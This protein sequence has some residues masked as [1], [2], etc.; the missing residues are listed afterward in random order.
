MHSFTLSLV[1]AFDV[2]LSSIPIVNTTKMMTATPSSIATQLSSIERRPYFL[3][4]SISPV[5][6]TVLD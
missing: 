4:P 3:A 2:C 6:R 5:W 1:S